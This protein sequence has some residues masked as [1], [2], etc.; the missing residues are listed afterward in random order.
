M[1]EYHI[2]DLYYLGSIGGYRNP[3]AN[4]LIRQKKIH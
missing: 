2:R 1:V 3:L 4:D